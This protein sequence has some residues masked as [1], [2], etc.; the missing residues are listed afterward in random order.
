MSAGDSRF[1][2]MPPPLPATWST[3]SMS[4]TALTQFSPFLRS[5]SPLLGTRIISSGT[6]ALPS[7]STTNDPRNPAPPVT[8]TLFPLQ[9]DISVRAPPS[10]R[11]HALQELVPVAYRLQ[12]G[13]PHVRVDHDLDQSVELDPEV[14]A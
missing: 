7:R 3:I 1:A 11:E 6:P 5:L 13:G 12:A 10:L 2:P 8:R 14:Q 4:L 9:N